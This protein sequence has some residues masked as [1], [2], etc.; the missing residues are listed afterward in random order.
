MQ[1]NI[2]EDLSVSIDVHIISQDVNQNLNMHVP[3]I[4]HVNLEAKYT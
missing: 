1:T 2:D 3:I 4:A